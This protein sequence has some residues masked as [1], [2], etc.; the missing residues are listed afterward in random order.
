MLLKLAEWEMIMD[1]FRESVSQKE[2]FRIASNKLLNNCFLLKKK[3]NTK[4]D[5]VFVVQN[6]ELFLQYFE[7]L[8]YKLII[9]QEQGVIGLVNEFGT[10]RLSL[11]KYESILLLICRLLYIEKRKEIGV[12]SDD[13]V[14][15]MDEIHDKYNMLKIKAKPI[16]DKK[17]IRDGISLFRRYNLMQNLDGD[18]TDYDCR[19]LIYPSINMAITPDNINELHKNIESKLT[20]Y[21]G[22]ELDEDTD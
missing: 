2:K 12:S 9:N 17:M 10:G 19:I 4:D 22:G 14:V 1:I 21:A 18:V 16:M 5:Y 7:L 11:S 20:Q 13:V 6:R 3:N 8:G 15:L